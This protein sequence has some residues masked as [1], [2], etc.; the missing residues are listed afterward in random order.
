MKNRALLIF[1]LTAII[2]FLPIVSLFKNGL[3]VTHDGQD[4]V[5]RIANFYQSLSE[6]NIVPRWAGNLNWGYGHPILMFL[7]PLPSHVASLFHFFGLSLVN[8]TKAV[9]AVSYMVS[10][11]AMFLWAKKQWGPYA[12]FI[13]SLVYGFAPYRFVDLYVRGAI[14]EHVAFVFPPLICWGL[15]MQ[16]R[17]EYFL[18]SSFIISLGTASLVLSH[19]A[20]SLVF[21][22]IIALY[23]VYLY[24]FETRKRMKFAFYSIMFAAQGLLVSSFFWIP[25]FFEGKYTLRDIVTKGDV[26][27]RFVPWTWFFYSPWNYGGG[28]QFSKQIGVLNWIGLVSGGFILLKNISK[29]IDWILLGSLVLFVATLFFMTQ[30]SQPIWEKITILQKFQFPWRLLSASVFISSV[31]TAAAMT[32]ISKKYTALAATGSLVIVFGT[33][34]QMWRP[35]SYQIQPDSYYSGVYPSTTDTGESSPIWS[36]R[37]MEKSPVTQYEIIEGKGTII[38]QL[39]TTTSHMFTINTTTK[40]RVVDNTLYFPGWIVS[41]DNLTTSIEFQDQNWRG[42][43]TFWVN[44]GKHNVVVSFGDTKLRKTANLISIVG[45]LSLIITISIR[46]F[47]RRYA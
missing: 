40:V 36:V 3:P 16:A 25:A 43:M 18:L 6:G 5:A 45:L 38:P 30:L 29:K 17:R 11:L 44:P 26:I 9:F 42:L 28:D 33:T 13:A 37:F 20:L 47:P 39:R 23:G 4:H 31:A 2:F 1:V 32:H 15:L 22:P 14:G 7:Y 27:H 34:Y 41:V 10:I 19:N 46:G 21:F 35:K 8:S 12:A 24:F